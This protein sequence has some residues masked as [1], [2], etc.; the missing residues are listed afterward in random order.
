MKN[1]LRWDH[2]SWPQIKAAAERDALV[3]VPM[4]SVE[5][6]GPHLP[7]GCDHILAQAMSER[8]AQALDARGVPVLVAPTITVANSMH[9]MAFSG[10]ISLTP[11][12]FIAAFSEQCRAIKAHGFRKIVVINGHGG[13]FDPVSVA[14][15][16]L[17]AELGFPVYCMGYWE[18]AQAAQA[19]ILEGQK[20]II[21]ACEG[22]TSL[23]LAVDPTLVDP[24][25]LETEG[26]T[27]MPT[28]AEENG[29]IST[30]RRM[31]EMTENGVMGLSR[32]ATA[33]KGERMIAAMVAGAVDV[34][35]APDLWPSN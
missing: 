2:L 34:L 18:G 13:N 35:T 8:I 12:T 22:E 11:Q 6:H 31:E 4:G 24:I 27:A 30:F 7:V 33:E 15:I 9:H 32:L 20:G 17:N 28:A 23:M 14:G 25:Y 29:M 21:H 1:N 10:T 19:E 16:T 5:Q 3:L 26:P